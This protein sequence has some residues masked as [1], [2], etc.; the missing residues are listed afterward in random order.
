M[1]PSL[2]YAHIIGEGI[3]EDFAKALRIVEQGITTLD[4]NV[5]PINQFRLQTTNGE[6]GALDP[7]AAELFKKIGVGMKG[8]TRTQEGKGPQSANVALRE[9]LGLHANIRPVKWFPGVMTPVKEPQNLDVV[10]FRQNT[11]DI[12]MGIEAEAGSEK[13]NKLISFIREQWGYAL[14]MFT[15]DMLIGGGIKL[16]SKKASEKIMQ[17]AIE[18]ALKYGRKKI[19]VAHKGNIMK[20]TEGAFK[21]WCLDYAVAQYRDRVYL[22]TED[23]D[24][25][26]AEKASR[27][28]IDTVITDDCFSQMLISPKR[29][30]VIVTMNLNGDYLSDAAAAQIGGVPT[31]AGGNIGDDSAMFEAI[32][33]TADDI[34]GQDKAN[35]TAFLLA[36]AMLLEYKGFDRE[37][38]ALRDAIADLYKNQIGTGDMH[39]ATTL[40]TSEFAEQV[41]DKMASILVK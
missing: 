39:F 31:A 29:F 36:F 6:Q 27:L 2:T 12:Y 30:D 20:K 1:K 7:A 37:A 9:Y 17:S 32:G 13:M 21:Q 41:R 14:S 38:N 5:I 3:G 18:Y 4:I 15:D 28:F 19:C 16:I 35:P 24:F 33:G 10:I 8:P 34:A 26:D 25:T 22:K 11:E 40:S 23:K